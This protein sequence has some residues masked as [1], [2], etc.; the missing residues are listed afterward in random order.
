M[1]CTC[2]IPALLQPPRAGGRAA[3]AGTQSAPAFKSAPRDGV[4]HGIGHAM[5][6]LGPGFASSKVR[7]ESFPSANGNINL[8]ASSA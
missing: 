8:P 7:R 4:D 1:R 2:L 3:V 5:H 6:L